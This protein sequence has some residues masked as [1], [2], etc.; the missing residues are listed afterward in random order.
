M[1]LQTGAITALRVALKNPTYQTW[2]VVPSTAQ[3]SRLQLRHGDVDRMAVARAAGMDRDPMLEGIACDQ[4]HQAQQALD[5][6]TAAPQQPPGAPHARAPRCCLFTA[7]Y[8]WMIRV[9]MPCVR[10][11]V[12]ACVRCVWGVRVHAWSG[13]AAAVAHI[14]CCAASCCAVL[15][16]SEFQLPA[17]SGSSK[18]TAFNALLREVAA[19]RL[20]SLC[21]EA[22]CS[23]VWH[24]GPPA[25]SIG[26]LVSG[27]IATELAQYRSILLRLFSPQLLSARPPSAQCRLSAL[28]DD[29]QQMRSALTP[30]PAR[31][32][33]IRGTVRALRALLA[34]QGW[35]QVEVY[36]SVAAGLDTNQSDVDL[37]ICT[38]VWRAALWVGTSTQGCNGGMRVCGCSACNGLSQHSFSCMLCA[39]PVH[40]LA[41]GCL[42]VP[43]L[44]SQA[45]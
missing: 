45:I 10:V 3:L 35:E 32:Q 19:T 22:T 7:L 6:G 36:G 30:L 15:C 16:W 43:R 25:G 13:D 29:V 44:S 21:T 12:R 42:P 41:C 34:S 14:Q 17:R 37:A 31:R 5:T 11:C 24:P 9:G 18:C 2:A 39:D 27:F 40:L 38:G 26:A 23:R 20:V 1:L 8:R 4:L 28:T 33:A